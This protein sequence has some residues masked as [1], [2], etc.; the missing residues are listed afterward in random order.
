MTFAP[1]MSEKAQEMTRFINSLMKTGNKLAIENEQLKKE[2]ADLK[3]KIKSKKLPVDLHDKYETSLKVLH[4][5]LSKAG[6]KE[7]AE[8]AE[9]L[10][11]E[12][13]AVSAVT[14]KRK[15]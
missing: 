9:Y 3:Q 7:G 15:N 8:T 5:M 10:L 13:Q 1:D 2:N 4:T 11:K 6:L 12:L 14:P